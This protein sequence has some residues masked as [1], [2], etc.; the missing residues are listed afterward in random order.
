MGVPGS[1]E[2]FIASGLNTEGLR[3]LLENPK[4]EAGDGGAL[5]HWGVYMWESGLQVD[6]P[7]WASL[8]FEKYIYSFRGFIENSVLF[9]AEVKP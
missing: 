1:M 6:T 5:L 4:E 2:L 7:P 3:R 9:R 8:Q